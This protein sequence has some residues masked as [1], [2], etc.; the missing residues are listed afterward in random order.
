MVKKE[1]IREKDLFN[2]L[3][4]FVDK[5]EA[6]LIQKEKEGFFGWDDE[7]HLSNIELLGRITKALGERKYV[8]AANMCMMLDYRKAQRRTQRTRAAEPE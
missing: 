8:D 4:N 1:T 5:M 3:S 7:A 2:A 6:R